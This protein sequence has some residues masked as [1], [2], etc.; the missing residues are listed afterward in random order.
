MRVANRL[1]GDQKISSKA[2]KEQQPREAD[3][4]T[5]IAGK[6]NNRKTSVKI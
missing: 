4:I 6:Q 2:G 5:I 3:S 1:T